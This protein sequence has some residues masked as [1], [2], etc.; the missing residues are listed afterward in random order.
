MIWLGVSTG[1]GATTR[2]TTSSRITFFSRCLPLA[3]CPAF[4]LSPSFSFPQDAR[5]VLPD[6]NGIEAVIERDQVSTK[7]GPEINLRD[8]FE[9]NQTVPAR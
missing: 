9:P 7:A 8:F 2:P 3:P 1:C 5:C 6:I 4:S